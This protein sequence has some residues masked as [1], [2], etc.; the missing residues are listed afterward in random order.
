MFYAAEPVAGKLHHSSIMAGAA[1]RAAGEIRVAS[2]KLVG[3]T[4]L[5]GHYRPG[6]DHLHYAVLQLAMR[7]VDLGDTKVGHIVP[8]PDGG[9]IQL[10]WFRA[11]PYLTRYDT[12]KPT[13]EPRGR[14][15]DEWAK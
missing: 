8:K 3:V 1:V 6:N 4:P 9:G 11:I 10:K 5:S 7:G 2:G 15:A 12:A 14:P 13:D